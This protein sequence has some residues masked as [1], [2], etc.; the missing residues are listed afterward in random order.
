MLLVRAV[1]HVAA[2]LDADHPRT[3]TLRR[4][5]GEELGSAASDLNDRAPGVC[6][7]EG[8]EQRDLVLEELALLATDGILDKVADG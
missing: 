8:L 3:V 4:E 5:D 2:D 1:D 7:R 6:E